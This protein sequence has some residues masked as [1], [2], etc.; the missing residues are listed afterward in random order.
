MRIF[1]LQSKTGLVAWSLFTGAIIGFLIST[2]ISFPLCYSTSG[3]PQVL[4]NNQ[5][6]QEMTV[7]DYDCMYGVRDYGF[8]FKFST[9]DVHSMESVTRIVPDDAVQIT[10]QNIVF[11]IL[12]VLIIL[13]L[14]RYFKIKKV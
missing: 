14:I 12:A 6:Q 1:S 8:P 10:L 5:T 3:Q 2:L 7:G 4:L 11:W 13:S 9:Q